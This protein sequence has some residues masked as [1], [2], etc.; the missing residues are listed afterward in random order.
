MQTYFY[1][2]K[3]KKDGSSYSVE[4]IDFDN[5]FTYGSDFKDAYFMAQDVLFNMLP[6]YEVKPKPTLD[7]MNIEVGPD[8]FITLVELNPVKHEL[9]ISKKIVNTTVTMPQWLKN[10]AEEKGLNYSKILQ[11]GIKKELNML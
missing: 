4:F 6:E 5:V 9:A 1:P 11:E 10:L 3:F 2:A 7:Y 8:E